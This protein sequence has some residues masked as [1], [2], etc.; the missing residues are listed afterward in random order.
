MVAQVLYRVI[1]ISISISANRRPTQDLGPKPKGKK[2]NGEGSDAGATKSAVF[3]S[4][5]S[6][7]YVLLSVKW[8]SSVDNV[9]VIATL[10]CC[11]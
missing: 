6:G 2:A 5:R 8:D 9:L 10:V 11:N 1:N 3:R 7:R 4:H